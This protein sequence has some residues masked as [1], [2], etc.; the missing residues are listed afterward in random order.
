MSEQK[1]ERWAWLLVFA[2]M[3]VPAMASVTFR[4]TA[5]T[6][7]DTVEVLNDGKKAGDIIFTATYDAAGVRTSTKLEWRE[8]DGKITVVPLSLDK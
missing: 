4:T 6:Y 3:C 1:R 2:V 5:K 7:T 8:L